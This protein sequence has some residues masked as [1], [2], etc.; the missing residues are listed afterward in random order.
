M[1]QA[2][3]QSG[4]VPNPTD[5]QT[6][7]VAL[8]GRC[9]LPNQL[10][11]PCQAVAMSPEQAVLVSAHS[12]R[13]GDRAIVYLDHLGR[14]EGITTGH[15][16]GGFTVEIECTPRKRDKLAKQIEQLE[17]HLQFGQDNQRDQ[18][19]IEPNNT[20]SELK[21]SD[22]RCYPIKIIDI[23]LSGA[24]VA[25][26]V[27]PANGS[28]VWLAGMQGTVIRHFAEGVGIQFADVA[29]QRTIS[30]RFS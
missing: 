30:S 9:M 17:S 18:Q 2:I 20:N 16:K 11:I 14:I 10:E 3:L 19:R 28:K 29:D 26:E 7:P 13:M 12:P 22:G 27:K 24:A 21:L 5:R 6:T 1:D 25:I 8:F 23:S 15:F 4:Q